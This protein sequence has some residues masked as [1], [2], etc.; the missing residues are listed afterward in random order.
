MVVK[1]QR[2][3]ENGWTGIYT[4]QSEMVDLYKVC[5]QCHLSLYTNGGIILWQSLRCSTIILQTGLS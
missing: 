5:S 3:S 1:S 4:P 2:T